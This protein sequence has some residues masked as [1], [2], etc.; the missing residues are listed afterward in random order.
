M[1]AWDRHDGTVITAANNL[2]LKVWN[3]ITGNL[4]HVLMVRNDILRGHISWLVQHFESRLLVQMF[5]FLMW[6]A[7]LSSVTI[8]TQFQSVQ[9]LGFWPHACETTASPVWSYCLIFDVPVVCWQGHEDEVFVLEPHPFDPRIL[10]SAGHDGNC[11]VWDLARGVKIRSYFNM[12]RFLSVSSGY[13]VLVR[14]FFERQ[15]PYHPLPLPLSSYISLSFYTQ[16]SP[17]L[18]MCTRAPHMVKW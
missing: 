8:R 10:F 12:V 4:V 14:S 16:N 11:I 9:R 7:L 18:R 17:S 15:F 5:T 1:V 3:S 13:R 2:T 6:L